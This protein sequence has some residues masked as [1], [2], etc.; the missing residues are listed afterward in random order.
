MAC[1]FL[2]GLISRLIN[3]AQIKALLWMNILVR[4]RQP[5]MTIVQYVWPCLVFASLYLVRTKFEATEMDACQ[6]PTRQLPSDNQLLHSIHSYICTFENECL[7]VDDY[8]EISTFPDAPLTPAINIIQLFLN[9]ASLFDAVMGLS[10]KLEFIPAIIAIA[11]NSKFH[12]LEENIKVIMTRLPEYEAL[13]GTSFDLKKLFADPK[14]L[15]ESGKIMC[16]K[17]FPQADNLQLVKQI[18]EAEDFSEDDLAEIESMPTPFCKQLYKDVTNTNYGKITW[19]FLKPV[20]QGKI[21]YGPD[22]AINSKIIQN[23]NSTFEDVNK[24]KTFAKAIENI[25][26][27]VRTDDEVRDKFLKLLQLAK[28]PFVQTI[29]SSA[30]LDPAAIEG[31]FNGVLYD[32]RIPETVSLIANV[33]DC[34]SVDRF[35]PVK[36]EKDLEE[37]A[38]KLFEKKMFW[39]GILFNQRGEKDFTYKLRMTIDDTPK[40]RELKSGF[41]FPGPEASFE[42]DL[43]YHRGFI[44]LQNLIEMG[45]IKSQ[46]ELKTPPSTEGEDEDDY[47]DFE[48]GLSLETDDDLVDDFENVTSTPRTKVE[49]TDTTN[50]VTVDETTTPVQTTEEQTDTTEPTRTRSKR[51]DMGNLMGMM[52]GDSESEEYYGYQLSNQQYYT[53]QF[54]Y[55]RYMKDVLKRGLFMA[56]AIQMTFFF[57]LI[58]HIAFILRDR[59]WIKESGNSALMRAMG[60]LKASENISW[61]MIACAELAFVFFA[62]IVIMYS[63]DILTNTNQIFLFFYLMTY[64]LCILAFCY[65]ISSFFTSASMASV[66]SVI[67]FLSTFLPYV[68]IIFFEAKLSTGSRFFANLSFSTAFCNAW[69][70]ILRHEIQFKKVSFSN[71]FDGS[72]EENDFKYGYLMMVLDGFLYLII[73]YIYGRFKDTENKFYDVPTRNLDSQ[74]GAVLTK[75]SKYY[76]TN[77]LA[78]SSV[79][80]AFKRDQITCLLGR[81]GAGKSTIIKMLTGQILP[82]S[83]ELYVQTSKNLKTKHVGL[84]SQ[85]N[86]L[87]PHLT[88]KE[89]LALYGAIKIGQDYHQEVRRVLD[90]LSLG[91]YER[92]KSCEL[93][94]G[95]KRRLSIGIAFLGSP[96]LVILDEPCSS[97]D[98]PARKN[99]WDLVQSLKKGRAIVLATHYLDEAEHLGDNIVF[100]NNGKVMAETVPSTVKNELTKSFELSAVMSQKEESMENLKSVLKDHVP[101]ANCDIRGNQVSIMLPYSSNGSLND[102]E[103]LIKD[104]EGMQKEEKVVTFTITSKNLEDIFKEYEE[105]VSNGTHHNGTNMYC[106]E[107][108]MNNSK[109]HKNTNSKPQQLSAIEIIKIL[110][111][112]RITH[113]RRNY[114]VL[115][116]ILVLPAIFE[117]LAMGFFKLRPSDDY[118]VAL[119][120]T[121]DIYE[122]S[123]EFYSLE[124]A[125][126]FTE[127]VYEQITDHCAESEVCE[128]F[129]NSREAHK[130]I[131]KTNDE[132]IERRYGGNTFNGTRNVV[133]YNNK[134]YHSMPSFLNQFNNA[135][136]KAELND[137][138]YTI[139]A[140]NHP[141][142]VGQALSTS[143]VL[144]QVAD[145]G[146][147]LILLIAM[148]LVLAG[149]SVFL[150]SE[151]VSGEKLQQKLCGINSKI[152]W[153]VAFAWDMII[154]IVAI[155]LAMI[156]FKIFAL[157]IFTERSQLYGFAMLL[158]FFGFA[159]IP[160][161]HVAEKFFS[162]ASY[163][164]M[165]IFCLN[166]IV[167]LATLAIILMFD[168][169]GESDES[170]KVRNFLNRAFLIFPQHALSDGLLELC[171]NFITAVFFKKFHIDSYKNP[172]ASDLLAPHISALIVIGVGA[173]ITNYIIESG[174]YRIIL[175]R[176]YHEKGFN[177]E[178]QIVSIQNSMKKDTKYKD[179]NCVVIE[180]LTKVYSR[181]V[182]ALNNVSF[183]VKTGE[184]FGLLGANGAGKSTV[185]GILSGQFKETSGRIE[186]L[187]CKGISYCPQSN[188]VDDLLTVR[189]VIEF[190]GKLR[191]VEDLNKLVTVTLST[192]HLEQYEH[193]LVKNLSGGNKRKLSVA[194]TCL[195]NTSL[196]LMDEPTS[197]MDPVTRT[198]VYKS[199]DRLI[200]QNRSVLLTSHTIAEIDSVCHRIAILKNGQIIST[201]TPSELKASYGNS[202]A[203][204]V[205][206]DKVEELTI[207]RDLK[208]E[209]PNI[210]TLVIHCHTLQFIVEIKSSNSATSDESAWLLSGLFA[211]LHQFCTDRNI[212]YSVSQ[213]L[214]DRVFERI[215]ES[216]PSAYVNPAFVQNE[217]AT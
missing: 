85:N 112:K 71:A 37:Q 27:K 6:F 5:L 184:C 208:R 209:F 12:L 141:F 126:N 75:V 130:W 39:A 69:N 168:I 145:A 42:L 107:K 89:H 163:A 193:V 32:D 43:R 198:L 192:Y 66:C 102:Y 31:M 161:I 164:N 63:G 73:G 191:L 64:G 157:P 136:F 215:L 36:N 47:D 95:Y 88:A 199:I 180:N 72:T 62:A 155:V 97:L 188:A 207:E 25:L 87:I 202:Y 103:P 166:I 158:F 132:Y 159:L 14:M 98:A 211:K 201:G 68:L 175:A 124:N 111:W 149:A 156:I 15:S 165:T 78:V 48:S 53:K 58:I 179:K 30:N 60:L 162:D 91:K 26:T 86:I 2:R 195:G 117:M 176:F 122:N 20:I 194:V 41:W 49:A 197:D 83:G 40:T 210:E 147:A 51:A 119:K 76:N 56:H 133:W 100:M 206:F 116:G 216:E 170:I 3:I 204:T 181:G 143:S 214:L 177:G 171:K 109:E 200:G 44:Q 65:M 19:T 74:T 187:D 134:G 106:D 131:L 152:Y 96:S 104:L 129:G 11:T 8:E 21:L 94:G 128:I 23:T 54:P 135:L 80:L 142:K 1:D 93:S 189:E 217:T 151:R 79:S 196:V 120:F 127:K 182:L 18:L 203:V 121:P 139:E 173:I 29:M 125:V 81:N 154:Y 110:F 90:V 213:C 28:S 92:Y 169:I 150:V 57:A 46:K 55:P 33:M 9:E 61:F 67:L 113:F 35:V 183:N 167:A 146:I 7:P 105:N 174:L 123:K 22:N 38:A 114:R 160:C 59:V 137:S 172:L 4:F 115:I 16:G 153:I 99:I 34:F 178:L 205:F 140:T 45:I 52:F 10:E 185:F 186:F 212:S 17:S 101:N 144:Q 148:S 82:S 190:Y 13:L 70:F 118:D 108:K 50:N 138:N 84:C 77:K 24:L